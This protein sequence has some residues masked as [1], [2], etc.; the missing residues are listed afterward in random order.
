MAS[1]SGISIRGIGLIAAGSLALIFTIV[2]AVSMIFSTPTGSDT[3]DVFPT[4]PGD[5]IDIEDTQQGGR[6]LVTIVDQNDPTRVASTLRAERF[7]PIGEGRRRLDQPE[8]WIFLEDGRAIRV[9]ADYATMLM[10]DPN[11]APESGTLEGNIL[12]RA[13]DSTPA[14]GQPAPDT[15]PP[16]LIARFDQPVEFERRY[17]R[18]RSAGRFEI[19]SDQVDFSGTDLTVILNDLRNR[20][21]LIDVVRGDQLVIHTDAAR[22][23]NNTPT[24]VTEKNPSTASDQPNE[25]AQ[26]TEPGSDTAPPTTPEPIEPDIQRYIVTLNDQVTAAIAQNGSVNADTLEL[27][28]AFTDGQLPPDAIKTIALAQQPANDPAPSSQTQSQPAGTAEASA[29]AIETTSPVPGTDD[30]AGDL[31]I[32]WSGPMRVRPIDGQIPLQLVEDHLALRLSSNEGSG[33][34]MDAPQRGFTGQARSVTYF[35]TRAIAHFIGEESETGIIRMQVDEAGTLIA[36]DMRVNLSTGALDLKQRGQITTLHADPTQT[37]SIRWKNRAQIQFALAEDGSITQR[38]SA[39]RFEGAAMAEQDG[40]SLGARVLEATLDPDLE[41]AAAL[42]NLRLT[43]GVISSA[44]NSLLSGRDLSIDF[45]P[46]SGPDSTPQPVRVVS[47]GSALGRTPDAMLRADEMSADLIVDADGQTRIKT[48]SA[49]GNVNYRDSKRTTAQA[50]QLSADGLNEVITLTGAGTSVTQAGST[51]AGEHIT[52]RAKRRGIEVLGPGTFDHDLALA[53]DQNAV[54]GQL[55]HVNARWNESMRFDDT[56]GTLNCSGGVRV[57]ST[58]DALTRDTINADKITINLTP[59][60]SADPVAGGSTPQRQL[61][62]ARASGRALPGKAPE[63][64][65]IESRSYSP[66][67]PEIATGVLYL[68]GGQIRAD[69]LKQTLEIPGAG[70][71]LVLDRPEE[72]QAPETDQPAPQAD[73]SLSGSGLTRFNWQSRMLLERAVGKGTFNGN[74]KVDH[75]SLKSNKVATLTTDTLIARFDAASQPA[76]DSTPA[77]QNPADTSLVGSSNALQSATAQGNVRFLFEGR[78]LLCEN[79]EYDAIADSLFASSVGN[80]LVTLYNNT[81]AAPVSAR[82]IR[83]DLTNDRT[84]INAPSPVRTTPGG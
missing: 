54:Q 15:Q 35:A 24:P 69:N 41:P 3:P 8:S 4:D 45:I 6:M 48:A 46:G 18:M 56:L 72:N 11:Q 9:N 16:T 39:A 47:S 63:P 61:I 19:E 64:A 2:V 66:I 58:P 44:S 21:E 38:L 29:P 33:I 27:W 28:A 77:V 52:L 26:A 67:N 22:Q 20:I 81:G 79:A 59:M 80:S 76:Q 84:V 31:V 78:E 68:E 32:T 25:R 71:L 50:R 49:S 65:S 57:I 5:F 53:Q 75:K 83:W 36:S 51:I 43:E 40:N 23:R 14:P 60:P 13:Y 17:L 70:T 74:V 82:T 34:T 30:G 1:P 55:G 62:S 12:L 73:R 37:A 7:E 42:K 10:P